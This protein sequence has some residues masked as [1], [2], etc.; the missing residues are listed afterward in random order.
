MYVY[1]K[2]TVLHTY[3]LILSAISTVA[4]CWA[5]TLSMDIVYDDI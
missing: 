3:A 5:I 1:R 2:L 4:S